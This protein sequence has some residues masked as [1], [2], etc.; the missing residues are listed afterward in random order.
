MFIILSS[1]YQAISLNISL[2]FPVSAVRKEKE[3][4]RNHAQGRLGRASQDAKANGALSI[5]YESTALLCLS[6]K[7]HT[8][9]PV[10]ESTEP[11]TRFP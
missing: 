8:V 4:R 9:L 5:A 1:R 10:K 11:L 3:H 2:L 7:K 6:H